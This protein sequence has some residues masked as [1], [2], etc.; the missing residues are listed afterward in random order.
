MSRTIGDLKADLSSALK[1]ISELKAQGQLP[2]QLDALT[3][4]SPG[5]YQRAEVAVHHREGNQRKV[6]GDA[7][8][9]NW[10][11]STW[12]VR[13]A[14]Q[15]AAQGASPAAG[16]DQM[17]HPRVPGE[18][19]DPARTIVKTLAEAE[20]E[21]P[22]VALKFLRDKLLPSIDANWTQEAED[23]QA[24]IKAAIDRR[25]LLTSKVPNPT[26]PQF[27]TTAVRVNRDDPLVQEVLREL[28]AFDEGF[29]PVPIRG[30]PLSQ[31]VLE[32]R[33]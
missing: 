26:A 8:A 21:M 6:R 19:T 29:A 27:P 4:L 17:T 30:K 31:T 20:V 2:Q 13:I 14:M 11:L 25:L 28:S 10:D 9:D 33:R 32:D 3:L 22:F 18:N 1:S 24:N 16:T 7:G 12:E 5:P 23:R 15:S